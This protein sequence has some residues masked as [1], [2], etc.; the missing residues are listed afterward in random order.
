MK[1]TSTTY[2]FL[3]TTPDKKPAYGVDRLS[4]DQVKRLVDPLLKL[5]KGQKIEGL[6]GSDEKIVKLF[7]Q[8][9]SNLFLWRTSREDVVKIY[10]S[11][12]QSK[13]NILEVCK[14]HDPLKKAWIEILTSPEIRSEKVEEIIGR[15][16]IVEKSYSWSY[17]YCVE[18]LFCDIK[19]IS[20]YYIHPRYNVARIS[21]NAY[22]FSIPAVWRQFYINL[23]LRPQYLNPEILKSLPGNL[24]IEN[25]EPNIAGDAIFLSGIS[26]SNKYDTSSP[27]KSTQLKSLKKLFTT[28]S[29]RGHLEEWPLDRVELLGNAFFYFTH[30]SKAHKKDYTLSNVGDFATF[31][32]DL[33]PQYLSATRLNMLFPAYKGLT[34]AWADQPNSSSL[35]NATNQLIKD[36]KD[37]WMSL[38]NLKLRYLCQPSS[39]VSTPYIHLFDAE[40][41]RKNTLRHRDENVNYG[42]DSQNSINWLDDINFPFILHWIKLLCA[43]GILEIAEETDLAKFKNDPLEGMR[44]VRLTPL[45]RYA[46]GFSETYSSPKVNTETSL[47]ADENCIITI[48]SQNCPYLLFINEISTPI[49]GKRYKVTPESFLKGCTKVGDAIFRIQNLDAIIDIKNN[50]GFQELVEEVK[51]RLDCASQVPEEFVLFKVKKDL[52]EFVRLLTTEPKLRQYV[53]LAENG[54]FLVNR[55]KVDA[56]KSLCN[57][58]GFLLK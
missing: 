17:D 7:N 30:F 29:F 27:V 13:V 15:E 42:Y 28:P 34:K 20:S 45:G 46:F 44:Y 40:A 52:P 12:T 16:I 41:R 19:I 35:C 8:A 54:Q 57:Q 4:S 32:V 37:G 21:R 38:S 2:N 49:S 50:K 31:V 53:I 23:L 1:K 3:L 48:L 26:Q 39:F 51:R 14:H 55:F 22:I 5:I 47:E 43:V 58:H 56:F 11:F 25:F 9:A 33:L 24:Q 10:K 6:P 36:A 18:P